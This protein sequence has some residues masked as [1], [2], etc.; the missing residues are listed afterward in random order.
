MTILLHFLGFRAGGGRSDAINIL[1]SLPRFYPDDRFIAV[2]PAG[3]GYESVEVAPNC[4]VR[5]E[6]IRPLHDA[7]R[8]YFDNVRLPGICR[9]EGVDTLFSMGNTG[10][11]FPPAGVRHVVMLRQPHFAY[12]PEVLA[13]WGMPPTRRTSV[14]RRYFALVLQR[15][16]ALITQTATIARWVRK[17]YEFSCPLFVIPK[18]VTE[19]IRTRNTGNNAEAESR[20]AE[21][22]RHAGEAASFRFLYMTKYYPHKGIEAACN[23]IR[24]ARERGAGVQLHLTIEPN[25]HPGAARLLAEIQAGTRPGVHSLGRVDLADV[26]SVYEAAD[27]VL[28]TSQ[29]ESF[30]ATYLEAMAY[31]RPLVASDRDFAREVCGEAALY[32]DPSNPHA[33]AA[34]LDRVAG[35]AVLRADL[36]KEGIERFR[37][38]DVGW[39][40]VAHRYMAVLTGAAE[41]SGI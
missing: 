34:A 11:V 24:I 27:A 21:A 13:Q 2:V 16:D 25:D 28:S 30:S 10:P 5:L 12:P 7:W 18:T 36:V 15:A 39:D 19:S 22:L 40:T 26:A 3:Y 23:A 17:G 32:A 4:Q 8:L 9:E 14:M 37:R 35:D 1:R 31:E 29:L 41:P 33:V 38:Y 6:R 20:Q